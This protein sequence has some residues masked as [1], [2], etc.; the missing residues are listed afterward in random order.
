MLIKKTALV[1]S[2]FKVKKFSKNAL[3]KFAKH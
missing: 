2:V 3:K 1:L